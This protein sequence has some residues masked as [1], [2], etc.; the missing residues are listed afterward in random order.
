MQAKSNAGR[1][2]RWEV[3]ELMPRF[4]CYRHVLTLRRRE[5][6]R[7]WIYANRAK[8]QALNGYVGIMACKQQQ[9]QWE[10]RSRLK[11]GPEVTTTTTDN[12]T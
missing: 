11:A 1:P 10:D 8:I 7:S 5:R 3:D 9:Q 6:R 12:A 2:T 4:K